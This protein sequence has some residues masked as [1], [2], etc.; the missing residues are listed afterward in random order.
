MPLRCVRGVEAPAGRPS[1]AAA[2]APVLTLLRAAKVADRV[3]Y[4]GMLSA[5]LTK[6]LCQF[7]SPADVRP[8]L[9][10]GRRQR[11]A[12]PGSGAELRLQGRTACACPA[13]C[14]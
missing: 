13:P 1:T 8:E 4:S 11:L 2:C 10:L 7:V 14:L 12:K 9:R 6:L 3:R 5:L